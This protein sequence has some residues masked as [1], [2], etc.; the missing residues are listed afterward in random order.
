MDDPYEPPQSP[1]LYI[2]TMTQDPDE[3][4]QT[5]LDGLVDMG[6]LTNGE[7]LTHG[8][9]HSHSGYTDLRLDA[10]GKVVRDRT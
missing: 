4:L 8:S 7:R 2:D 9:A 3:S 1:E 10:D 6:Y 5:I